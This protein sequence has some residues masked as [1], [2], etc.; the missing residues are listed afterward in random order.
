MIHLPSSAMMHLPS[1]KL[2]ILHLFIPGGTGMHKMLLNFNSSE[3]METV[4]EVVSG[5]RSY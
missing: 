3:D 5:G 1:Q 2:K 4:N